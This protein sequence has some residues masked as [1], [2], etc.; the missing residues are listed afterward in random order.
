MQNLK[1]QALESERVAQCFPLVHLTAPSMT[2]GE[3]QDFADGHMAQGH[4]E[5]NGILVAEKLGGCILGLA[6]YS[7]D[8]DPLQGRTL[9]VKNLIAHDYFASGRRQ[10]ERALITAIETLARGKGCRALH[11]IMPASSVQLFPS[12]LH[13]ALESEGHKLSGLSYCKPLPPTDRTF[14]G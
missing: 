4:P 2:A 8:R 11:V 7:F 6:V 12:G 5:P 3:W 1:I 10:V 9:L 13:D 14:H